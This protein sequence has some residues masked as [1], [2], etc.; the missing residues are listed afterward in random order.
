MPITFVG[1]ASGTDTATMPTHQSGDFI[2]VFAYRDGSATSPTPPTG[3]TH[4]PYTGGSSGSGGNLNSSVIGHKYA[5]SSSETVGTWTNATSTLVHVYRGVHATSPVIYQA[6]DGTTGAS[7]SWTYQGG[8]GTSRWL[9]LFGGARTGNLTAH[10]TPPSPYAGTLVNRSAVTDA[11]DTA[12]GHDS[13]GN[14][15]TFNSLFGGSSSVN[16]GNGSTGW[17]TR[18]VLLR[19]AD[20]RFYWFPRKASARNVF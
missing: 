11:T 2:L 15:I 17:R 18:D 19:P 10:T 8:T 6:D 16:W 13:N 20:E 1:A 9:V 4:T 5:I 3:Y 7:L 14:A 12:A